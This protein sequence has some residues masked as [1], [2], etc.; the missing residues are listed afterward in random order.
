[1][2]A[3]AHGDS[4][5][6]LRVEIIKHV[7]SKVLSGKLVDIVGNDKSVTIVVALVA[8]I[9]AILEVVPGVLDQIWSKV[10]VVCQPSATVF[11]KLAQNT[12]QQCPSRNKR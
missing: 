3:L 4:P 8:G 12:Y 10:Q 7:G 2:Q 11:V 5:E 1:L 9:D 6:A